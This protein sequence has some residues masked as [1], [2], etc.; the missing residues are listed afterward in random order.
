[1]TRQVPKK[2]QTMHEI[3]ELLDLP[4]LAPTVGSSIPSVFFTDIAKQMG[5]PLV[6]GMPAMARKIVEN[7]HL[8]W[9]EEFSSEFAPS[10]GGGTVTALGLVQ[11]KNAVLV[12]LGHNVEAFPS[13]VFYEIWN[14]REDWE[15]L[16]K[17]LPVE[18]QEVKS[19]PG[20]EQFRA[21]ILSNYDNRCAVSGFT[22]TETIDIAHV[23]P[24]YGVES[25]HE[26]NALPLRSDL[27]RLFDRGLL[28]ITYELGKKKYRVSIHDFA[29]I[30]YSEFHEVELI[31]PDEPSKAPSRQ[32]LDV[33][34]AIHKKYWQVI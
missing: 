29:K 33:H 10:G 5:I 20:A 7:S 16:K 15:E 18:L 21:L 23:V 9:S 32:A 12:W 11:V 19:R 28:R 6:A 3:A 2:I 27:H 4:P 17:Q 8:P 26:Q 31:T 22:T 34:Q 1:M 25:D 24:Y 14:P 13:G 30:D